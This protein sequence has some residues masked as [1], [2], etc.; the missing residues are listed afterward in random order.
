MPALGEIGGLKRHK[1]AREGGREPR[2]LKWLWVAHCVSG[3]EQEHKLCLVGQRLLHTVVVVYVAYLMFVVSCHFCC[4]R[5]TACCPFFRVVSHSPFGI[6]NAALRGLQ[7]TL[8]WELHVVNCTASA[9]WQSQIQVRIPPPF[10]HL[11]MRSFGFFTS[12]IIIMCRT[13]GV[14][15][16]GYMM[17]GFES[18]GVPCLKAC[19]VACFIP[20]LKGGGSSERGLVGCRRLRYHQGS[21]WW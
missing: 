8:I 19:S 3:V 17:C 6:S 15:S 16:C 11:Y 4:S 5:I 20:G 13:R 7:T 1:K 9:F 2:S 10:E 14:F 18:R 12:E 21:S